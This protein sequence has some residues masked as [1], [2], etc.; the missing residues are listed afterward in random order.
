MQLSVGL[1]QHLVQGL[2]E[3]AQG[4]LA[5]EDQAALQVLGEYEVGRVLRDRVQN[6]R[7]PLKLRHGLPQFRGAFLDHLLQMPAMLL[8]FL[9]RPLA[10]GDVDSDSNDMLNFS[11]LARQNGVRPVDQPPRSAHVSQW[12]SC[13]VGTRIGSIAFHASMTGAMPSGGIRNSQKTRPSTSAA[14]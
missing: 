10:L 7:R 5:G 6:L 13:R 14:G 2:T 9:L 8:Q 4:G 1:A 12:F 11:R 3:H